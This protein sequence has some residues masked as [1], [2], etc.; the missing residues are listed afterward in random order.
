M[1]LLVQCV[2]DPN[3]TIGFALSV[4]KLNAEFLVG[5]FKMRDSVA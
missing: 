1:F 2:V 4:S 3:E 5:L